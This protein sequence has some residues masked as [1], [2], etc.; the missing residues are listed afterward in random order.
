MAPW[1]CRLKIPRALGGDG[2]EGYVP[3]KGVEF[4]SCFS[5][6]HGCTFGVFSLELDMI[7]TESSETT[8][9]DLLISGTERHTKDQL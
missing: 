8:Y 5:L 7:L 4:E 2:L 6:I 1:I 3:L 9:V